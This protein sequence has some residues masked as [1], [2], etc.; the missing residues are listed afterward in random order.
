M[1]PVGPVARCLDTEKSIKASK[2]FRGSQTICPAYLMGWSYPVE[3]TK[4]R[5]QAGQVAIAVVECARGLT[6]VEIVLCPFRYMLDCFRLT[7][8]DDQDRF[9]QEPDQFG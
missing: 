4:E 8:F 3:A 7:R 6:V 9:V 5:T 1:R 2:S